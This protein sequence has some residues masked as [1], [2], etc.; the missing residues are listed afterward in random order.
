MLESF[1]MIVLFTDFGLH[2][3]YVGQMH[4]VLA[5]QAPGIPV[6]D[7]FHDVPTHDIRAGAY[8]LPAYV[9]ECPPET[10]VVA[11]VDPGVGGPRRALLVRADHR[12][13][14]GPDNC[15]FHP[16]MRRATELECREIQWSPDRLSASFHG[17]DLF[18]PVAAQLARGQ[19]P[20]SRQVEPATP[21]GSWPDDLA[22]VVY[23]DR[24]G[25]VLTGLR[26]R[27]LPP[28]ASLHADGVTIP[29]ARTYSEVPPGQLFW[30]ENS[31]GLAEIA[32]NCARAAEILN[33]AVGSPVG[34]K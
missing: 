17:R 3:P 15:L 22:E 23:V 26:A 30:Y 29:R 25:N 33:I 21:A 6:I 13:Y 16:L 10:V 34:I 8:L 5:Q 1:S 20:E 2:G 7:L 28:T 31:N 18:V 14:V 19:F 11:V 12:W 32:A 27:Q 24:F 4:A 9:R